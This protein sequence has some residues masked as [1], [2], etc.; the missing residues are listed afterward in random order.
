MSD[1]DVNGI[2]EDHNS[3]V[4]VPHENSSV[5]GITKANHEPTM[6]FA[7]YSSQP[8]PTSTI[9]PD[10]RSTPPSQGQNTPLS[11]LPISRS[12][13]LAYALQSPNEQV[14][15]LCSSA[16]NQNGS[17]AIQV[18]HAD[19]HQEQATYARHAVTPSEVN[20]PQ[21]QYYS[22]HDASNAQP[23]SAT[24]LEYVDNLHY[25]PGPIASQ[26][27]FYETP[28]SVVHSGYSADSRNNHAH[29][30]MAFDYQAPVPN[31][32]S[33]YGAVD[34]SVVSPLEH[35]IQNVETFV[36]YA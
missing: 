13:E 30:G 17:F 6:E 9:S 2:P 16:I 25:N 34:H 20:Q 31:V 33:T 22:T 27:Q 1:L 24:P 10:H 12:S 36:T 21:R 11:T 29:H 7:V 23:A 19:E 35:R 4:P 5:P 3:Y 28:N 14:C 32:Y 15:D 26:E 18:Q 8:S